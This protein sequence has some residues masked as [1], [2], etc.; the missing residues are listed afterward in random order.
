MRASIRKIICRGLQSD[1]NIIVCTH[2]KA[3][4]DFAAA[5]YNGESPFRWMAAKVL[6]IEK[7]F[8]AA[9]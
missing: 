9:T 7:N 3:V 5:F 6:N 4:A 8:F 2:Q 1:F